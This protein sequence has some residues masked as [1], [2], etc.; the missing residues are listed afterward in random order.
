MLLFLI[1]Y[2]GGGRGG[3]GLFGLLLLD[4]FSKTLLVEF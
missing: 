4:H 1:K 2:I 3:G